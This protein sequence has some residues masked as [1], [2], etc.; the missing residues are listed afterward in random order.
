M[1]FPFKFPVN[2]HWQQP[3]EG[4]ACTGQNKTVE[5]GKAR[6]L[7]PTPGPTLQNTIIQNDTT[8][9]N[10]AGVVLSIAK[11]DPSKGPLADKIF[12]KCGTY[13]QGAITQIS[14]IATEIMK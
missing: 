1:E 10:F 8:T 7:I 6:I 12:K 14:V 13:I 3:L 11:A 4:I 5:R 2:I 9:P